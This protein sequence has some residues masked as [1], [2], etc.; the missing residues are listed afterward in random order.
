MDRLKKISYE[1]GESA[2]CRWCL[3]KIVYD[4]EHWVDKD[5]TYDGCYSRILKEL[6]HG[7]HSPRPVV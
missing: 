5:G 2:T 6:H 1:A 4:G 3:E 7:R